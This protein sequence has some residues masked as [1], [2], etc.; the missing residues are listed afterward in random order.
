ML[1]KSSQLL[2]V[3]T[4]RRSDLRHDLAPILPRLRPNWVQSRSMHPSAPGFRAGLLTVRQ[5]AARVGVSTATL[6]RLC[7]RRALRHLGISHSIRNRMDDLTMFLK[8]LSNR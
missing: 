7:E 6:Y 4:P 1:G 3:S 2:E 8:L 5:V